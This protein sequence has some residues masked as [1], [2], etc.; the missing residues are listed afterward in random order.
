MYIAA[1][2]GRLN[3]LQY[4]HDQGCP[5]DKDS[6]I[7]TAAAEGGNREGHIE[8]LRFLHENGCHCDVKAYQFALMGRAMFIVDET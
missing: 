2:N 1:R 3:F 5:L 8:C 7:G 4:M 6:K